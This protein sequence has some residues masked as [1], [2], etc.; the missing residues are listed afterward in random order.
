MHLTNDINEAIAIFKRGGV[1]AYPTDTAY[2]LGAKFSD[3]YAAARIYKIKGRPPGKP[4]PVVVAS[5]GM[6][7]KFFKFSYAELGLAKKY[8][9][10]PLSLLLQ[11]KFPISN[12]QFPISIVVRM[13]DSVIARRLSRA[14]HEPIFSTSANIS[15]AGECYSAKEII[16][17]FKNKKEKPD[18]IFD[19]GRLR[20]KKP[21][22]I[23]KIVDD[24]IEVLR[25][26]PVR[27]DYKFK[28]YKS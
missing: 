5:L 28:N 7:R 14:V 10:G 12:F 25:K 9:P 26:G 21:S 17:Q 4:L 19:G 2:G 11:L 22:T 23:I 16:R 15:G 18:L 24:K 20:R 6:A 3:K 1:I 27:L 13:P 8:W